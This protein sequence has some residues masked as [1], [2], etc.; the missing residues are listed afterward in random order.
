LLSRKPWPVLWGLTL[1]ALTAGPARPQENFGWIPAAGLSWSRPVNSDVRAIYGG[2][3]SFDAGVGFPIIR[4]VRIDARGHFYREGGKPT[5]GLAGTAESR[6]T[7]IPL[8]VEVVGTFPRGVMR[9][10]LLAGAGL[11]LVRERFTYAL[12]E[13]SHTLTGSRQQ[14]GGIVGAGIEGDLSAYLLRLTF[15][16]YLSGG[17]REVLRPSLPTLADHGS[18]GCSL[19]TLGL[20]LARPLG[21][22][23]EG[24]R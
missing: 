7:L 17:K 1:M 3:L 2:G 15:R 22:A 16:A 13:E 21:S 18:A 11:T 10:F 20:E 9:P 12:F 19:F 5:P 4:G 24:R 23:A 14:M 6:L 8:G